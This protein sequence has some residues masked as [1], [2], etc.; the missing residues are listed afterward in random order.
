MQF[1]SL[2]LIFAFAFISK[3]ACREISLNP[4]VLHLSEDQLWNLVDELDDEFALDVG[5][6]GSSSP[7]IETARIL[8]R[9]R[10]WVE[11]MEARNTLRTSITFVRQPNLIGDFRPI[12]NPTSVVLGFLVL[13][14]CVSYPVFVRMFV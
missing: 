1:S 9:L 11:A 2:N 13:L 7:Q 12:L 14:L 3:Y 6:A 4:A 5:G 8:W 10:R